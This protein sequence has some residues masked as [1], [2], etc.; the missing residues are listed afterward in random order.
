MV[1]FLIG[2]QG[3]GKSTMASMLGNKYKAKIFNADTYRTQF[4]LLDDNSIFKALY[5]DA[6]VSLQKGE[7]VIFDNTN[8]SLKQRR[9]AV[10]WVKGITSSPVYAYVLNTPLKT[11]LQRVEARNEYIKRKVPLYVVESYASK[12]YLPLL[13]EGFDKI[14]I[15][16]QFSPEEAQETLD[17]Y[18]KEMQVFHQ[19]NSHHKLL[20]GEHCE[21]VAEDYE[22][23]LTQHYGEG[24]YSSLILGAR[25]HDVGKLFTQTFDENGESHYFGHHNRGAYELLS[26]AYSPI[27]PLEA[28][29]LVNYHMIPYFCQVPKTVEKY[30]QFLGEELWEKIVLFNKSDINGKDGKK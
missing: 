13:S 3:S 9:A 8:I 7:N 30:K 28:I 27:L 20:L 17:T 5:A 11:C 6:K 4:P 25:F 26:N 2:I 19:N 12:F 24:D 1:I 23:L 14:F 21:C 10:Q 18:W 22:R 15:H 16:N 29:A